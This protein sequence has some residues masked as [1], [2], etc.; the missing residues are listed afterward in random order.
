MAVPANFACPDREKFHYCYSKLINFKYRDEESTKTDLNL[1]LDQLNSLEY[2][3]IIVGEKDGNNLLTKLCSTIP[4]HDDRLVVKLCQ[5]ANNWKR[6]QMLHLTDECIRIVTDY[7]I[8]AVERCQGWAIPDILRALASVLYENVDRVETFHDRLLGKHGILVQ[9]INN[10]VTD[11][12]TL[13]EAVLCVECLTL[14]PSG[15]GYLSPELVDVCFDIFCMLLHKMPT[16]NLE[17][18]SQCKI[19]INCLRGIQ[20]MIQM[21]KTVPLNKLGIILAA[22]RAYMFYGLYTQPLIIPDSLYPSPLIKIDIPVLGKMSVTPDKTEKQEE[23]GQKKSKRKTKKRGDKQGGKQSR[24]PDGGSHG[25][26]PDTS[27]KPFGAGAAAINIE[28]DLSGYT[29]WSKI[30]SSESEW[31]DTEGGQG[32]RLR[33][34]CTKV[35]QCALSCFYWIIKMTDKKVMFS[36]WSSFI[37]DSQTATNMASTQTLFTIILKDPS[38]KCRMGALAALSVLVDG[39]KLLLTAAE[40]RDETKTATFTPFSVILGST[41]KEIHRCL[42]LAMI[43]EEYPITLTQLIKCFGTVIANVPYHRM[44]PGLLS[45]IVKQVKHFINHRDPNVRV[46]CLT[47]LGS[48]AGIQPPLME[49]CHIIQPS[50]P[51]VSA[52]QP[53]VIETDSS[54]QQRSKDSESGLQIINSTV[55]DFD[56]GFSSSPN[57]NSPGGALQAGGATGEF[58][59]GTTPKRDT[60]SSSGIQTPVFSD[61]LLQAYSKEISWVVKLC[62]KNILPQSTPDTV[63]GAE[64]PHTEPIPVRLESLQVLANLTKGYFPIIRNCVPLLQELVHKCFCD[65]DPVIKLHTA[66]LLD[67]FTQVL[68]QDVINTESMT[69]TTDTLDKQQVCYFY[70]SCVII[71]KT[72]WIIGL[73]TN[74]T[75]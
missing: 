55:R 8:K 71:Q 5:I 15:V 74:L 70:R 10:E 36:F 16:T 23:S 33:S 1:L 59:G 41:V 26:D 50:K 11:T 22:I 13:K 64:E 73:Q 68:L 9:L 46:A 4:L 31:S 56:S 28:A 17:A 3:T 24:Q 58:S 12:D 60:A 43:S 40:D 75:C 48:M 53:V 44:R 20:N 62:V 34:S 38:P 61:Q 63:F 67:E 69:Q 37:P 54:N 7:F 35:R 25:D 72:S 57:I 30:S 49:V 18:T 32:S 42:L 65:K 29:T 6:K 14:K 47:C 39:T 2:S 52:V 66:K 21:T 19:Q 27:G 51:P 45:R